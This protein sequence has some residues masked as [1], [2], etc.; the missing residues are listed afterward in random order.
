MTLKLE[1]AE[2]AITLDAQRRII[3]DATVVIDGTR[4]THIGKQSELHN[5]PAERT[6]D[7]SGCVLLPAFVNGHMHIS[8]AHAVRGIFPDDIAGRIRLR[9]VFR[10][11]SAMSEEE[12]YWT[13]LLAIIE[14]VKSGTLTFVDPGS[15][16][17]V[18]A[19]LQA[20]A[21]SGCCVITGTCVTDQPVDLELPCF[22]TPEAVDKSRKFIAKYDGHLKGRVRAWA[23]PFSPDTC[24]T[25]LLRDSKRVAD[26]LGTWMTFHHVGGTTAQLES[27]GVLGPNVL[28]AHASGIDDGEVD[29]IARTGATVVMCPSTTLKE[30][31]G[32]GRRKLPE[33]LAHGVAV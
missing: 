29:I 28:L 11:Q 1:G 8:Y 7:A 6:I 4:I 13:S 3:R 23:M 32:I 26:E 2:F 21:E 12:E 24:S 18:D 14:L 17:Y 27:N 9:E 31:S 30:G 15:T 20:Y 10:L 33:L 16:K 25:E 19:C 5:I 22:S